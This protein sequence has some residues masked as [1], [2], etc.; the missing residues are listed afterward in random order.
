MLPIPCT[1]TQE[2]GGLNA[3]GAGRQA[4]A[5]DSRHARHWRGGTGTGKRTRSKGISRY[6]KFGNEAK[7]QHTRISPS[8]PA[9]AKSAG[10]TRQAG[11]C[12]HK[13][14]EGNGIAKGARRAGSAP[15]SGSQSPTRRHHNC[16]RPLG[17]RHCASHTPPGAGSSSSS[18]AHVIAVACRLRKS[19]NRKANR[20]K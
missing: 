8:G 17:Q 3:S 6:P 16:Q 10:C 12:W 13:G 15:A 20:K 11:R 18:H 4:R 9:V 7:T 5:R 1:Q 14:G 19:V 2:P